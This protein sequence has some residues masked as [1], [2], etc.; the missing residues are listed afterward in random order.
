MAVVGL[1]LEVVSVVVLTGTR[2]QFSV[3]EQSIAETHLSRQK[4]CPNGQE[5]TKWSPSFVQ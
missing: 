4:T 2:Q 3:V 1:L 5:S